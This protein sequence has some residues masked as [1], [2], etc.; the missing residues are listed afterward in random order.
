MPVIKDIGPIQ[1]F[2]GFLMDAKIEN[3]YFCSGRFIGKAENND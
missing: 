3:R 1:R 2:G